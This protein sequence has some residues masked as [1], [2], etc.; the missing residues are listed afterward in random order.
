MTPRQLHI[1]LRAGRR[2]ASQLAEAAISFFE[3]DGWVVTR[4]V[5]EDDVSLPAALASETDVVLALGGDGTFLE[6][7]RLAYPAAAVVAGVNLGRLGYLA[8]FEPDEAQAL[9]DNIRSDGSGTSERSVLLGT[10][11][12][13]EAESPRQ[14]FALNEFTL[15]KTDPGHLARVAVSINGVPFATYSADG[16][17]IATPTGSTAYAMS[18]RGPIVS[19]GL[20]CLLFVPVA[21]HMLFDRAMVLGPGDVIECRAERDCVVTADGRVAQKLLAGESM[22]FVLGQ[23][24][25]RLIEAPRDF[26]QVLRQKFRLMEIP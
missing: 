22:K 19:P 21:P 12:A 6:A 26:H 3:E 11:S 9:F 24:R 20:D 13:A 16:L 7:V 25:L 10:R 18:A 23:R 15:E 4:S 17:I 8:G 5:L 1:V 14:E 2:D